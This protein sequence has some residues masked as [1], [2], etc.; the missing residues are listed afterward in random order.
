VTAGAVGK[1]A[2][3]L[4]ATRA[5]ARGQRSARISARLSALTFSSGVAIIVVIC[6]ISLIGRW[7]Y[8]GP[9][10][11][12]LGSTLQAPS[13]A[14]PLGTDYVGRDVLSRT[15]AATWVDLGVA[16]TAT[17]V[18]VLIG[19]ALGTMAGY[20]RGWVE[21]IIMRIVD[22]VIAFPFMVIVLFIITIIGP[23]LTGVFVGLISG[24]WAV[25]ARLARGEMLSLSEKSFIM[26]ARTLGFSNRRVI[27]RH[28]VPNLIRPC[29]VY[30]MSDI[31]LNILFVASL[32]Y[33]GLGVRPPMSEW[34]SI[35]A[36][37]QAYI[38]SAWWITTLPGC[39]LVV[40]GI[41]F[42]LIGDGLA[43]RLRERRVI[44]R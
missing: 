19:V 5:T 36:S 10:T 6:V 27:A 34:G 17:F 39:F 22:M 20:F 38:L 35:I 33:L 44:L 31:V 40:V 2:S 12:H 15:L 14:H 32:S 30:S 9:N 41:G 8:P 26:A 21:R 37:G 13:W 23:G 1:R 16:I 25:Y 18:S 11:I 42:S 28:A 3:A 43:D 24:G 4:R 29:L 7:A